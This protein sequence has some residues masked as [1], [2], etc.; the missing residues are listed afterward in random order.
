MYHI[1]YPKQGDT[2]LNTYL[3]G[4]EA[5]TSVGLYLPRADNPSPM[6]LRPQTWGRDR[7]N[8]SNCRHFNI[9][10]TLISID[11]MSNISRIAGLKCYTAPDLLS[12]KVLHERVAIGNYYY[13][14]F[15]V[16]NQDFDL[17]DE[18]FTP[19]GAQFNRHLYRFQIIWNDSTSYVRIIRRLFRRASGVVYHQITMVDYCRF[20]DDFKTGRV[21]SVHKPS[22]EAGFTKWI[23]PPMSSSR[24]TVR[25]TLVGNSFPTLNLKPAYIYAHL[26]RWRKDVSSDDS[27]SFGQLSIDAVQALKVFDGQLSL[28]LRDLIGFKG[29]LV[30]FW[31]GL[32]SQTIKGL[33]TA[34]LS[35][36]YG[37]RLTYRDLKDLASGFRSVVDGKKGYNSSRSR[38]QR[39]ISTTQ[40]SSFET[41]SVYNMKLYVRSYPDWIIDALQK[42]MVV[43]FFPTLELVWDIIPF[44]FVVDWFVNIGDYLEMV[45]SRTLLSTYQVLS[46]VRSRRTTVRGDVGDILPYTTGK[47]FGELVI[48]D[49]VRIIS[50]TPPPFRLDYT[51]PRSFNHYLEGA[52]LIAQRSRV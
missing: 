12:F 10:G 18:I 11:G 40:L 32:T 8:N 20:S 39:I 28:L 22:Y 51:K 14:H 23:E 38:L 7:F 35:Y 36:H 49:Y 16:V 31:T 2:I 1:I 33:S 29:L 50:R 41:T 15:I 25:S 37:L 13:T 30:S 42:M 6:G 26:W 24:S 4:G 45:D 47:V 48:T 21:L 9:E 17:T 46:C 43:D 27:S 5:G 34:Y 52:A 44:S 3:A 19:G